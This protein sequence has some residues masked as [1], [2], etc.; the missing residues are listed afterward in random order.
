M[1]VHNKPEGQRSAPIRRSSSNTSTPEHAAAQHPIITLQQQVGNAQIARMLAQ[2]DAIPEE[3][4]LLQGKHD[5]SI[6][7][8]ESAPEEEELLQGMHDPSIAQ[9]HSDHEDLQAK[10]EVGLEGGPVSDGVANQINS[11][12]GQGSSLS[13]SM[14]NSMEQSFGTSFEDVRVHTGTESSALNQRISARAFTTGNDIFLGQQAS[15]SDHSLMAHELT[16]VV[17]QRSMSGGGPMTVGPAGDSYEQQA[18]QMASAV[19]SGQTQR[20]QKD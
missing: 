5:P 15:A 2:R 17:Q 19:V 12:R 10:P 14:R 13:D 9:R 7:Q 11:M 20:K 3:E 8:R 6:A 1:P 18:D 4:E 16:H